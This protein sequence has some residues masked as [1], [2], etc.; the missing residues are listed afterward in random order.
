MFRF[1]ANSSATFATHLVFKQTIQV[2]VKNGDRLADLQLFHVNFYI[3][4]NMFFFS[5]RS[6]Y[7]NVRIRSTSHRVYGQHGTPRISKGQAYISTGTPWHRS[8]SGSVKPQS[9]NSSEYSGNINPKRFFTKVSSDLSNKNDTSNS[10]QFSNSIK[11]FF[12]FENSSSKKSLTD[13]EKSKN[14]SATQKHH[15][16][17]ILRMNP[18][19]KK[20]HFMFNSLSNFKTIK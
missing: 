14:I 8:R 1:E 7:P 13:S 19:I 9:S 17:Q 10:S 18:N 12:N 16:S 20:S 4:I 15:V 11:N 5:Y 6:A 2:I 3:L